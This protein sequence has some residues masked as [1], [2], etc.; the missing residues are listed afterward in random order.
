MTY[1]YRIYG[2]VMSMPFQ[3][4][5]LPMALEETAADVTVVEGVIAES[6]CSPAAK[7]ANWQAAPGRF[8]CYGGKRGGKLLVENGTKITLE[9]GS[10]A[11]DKVICAY[12]LTIVLAALL[13]QR[14]LLVLH[15]NVVI[16]PRG[17]VAISGESG[18]GKSTT[19]AAM[20][21]RG[22]NMLA[23]DLAVLQL[24]ERGEAVAIPGMPKLNLCEDTAVRLGHD[25]SKLHRN[26][27]RSIKVVVPLVPSDMPLLPAPLKAVYMLE[28]H[29]GTTLSQEVLGGVTKFTALQ[30]CI[31]GPLFPE[32]HP[33]IFAVITR[34]VTQ[35][36]VI[37]LKRPAKGWSV[38]EVV[39]AI[40]HG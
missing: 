18:S 11:E 30:D 20:L 9:R 4:P 38:N 23:D 28:R 8:V 2:F 36:E 29:H 5:L 21:T 34:L 13:R 14:G 15:A 12:L 25:V 16:T 10:D 24:N 32:E 17:A 3:C 1:K 37:R 7:G 19:Q 22:Y 40:L 6:N 35:V 26:P 39:E 33:G 31:Y 27:L